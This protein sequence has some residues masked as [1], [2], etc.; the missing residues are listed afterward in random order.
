MSLPFLVFHLLPFRV[1]ITT[2]QNGKHRLPVNDSCAFSHVNNIGYGKH[3]AEGYAR[4]QPCTFADG[5]PVT[6]HDDLWRCMREADCGITDDW[7]QM[8]VLRDPRPAI[9]STFYHILVHTTKRP[10]DLE[11]FVIRELPIICQLLAIRFI[12][13]AG[14]LAHRSIEFW[15]ADAM[16]D[17]LGWHYHWL[18]SVGLQLL[19]HVV[20]AMAQAAAAGNDSLIDT[21]PGEA[22]TTHPGVRQFED[23]VSPELREIANDT[24]RVWVPPVLL[25]RFGVAL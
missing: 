16:D 18:H 20:D 5:T 1:S 15:Y 8:A 19:F 17:P 10:R 12:L 23:E 7:I 22:T 6:N 4:K 3:E 9:V 25:E 21:H 2:A 11:A 14:I 24:L 13:F